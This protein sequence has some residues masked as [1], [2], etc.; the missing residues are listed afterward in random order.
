MAP[1]YLFILIRK[2]RQTLLT[3]INWL[4]NTCYFYLLHVNYY[5]ACKFNE[6]IISH[7][8][9]NNLWEVTLEASA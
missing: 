3:S 8:C 5:N 1:Y 4:S 7:I 9:M 6:K 2:Y